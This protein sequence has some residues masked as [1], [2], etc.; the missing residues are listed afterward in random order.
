MYNIINIIIKSW[1]FILER[2]TPIIFSVQMF[3][4]FSLHYYS[5]HF[6]FFSHFYLSQVGGSCSGK[7]SLVKSLA[8]LSGNKLLEYPMNTA[9]DTMELLGGFEQ[10]RGE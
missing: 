4:P 2:E 5:I 7:N 6:I 8:R 10:V 1:G 9:T 3:D